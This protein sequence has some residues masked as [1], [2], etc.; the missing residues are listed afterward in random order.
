MTIAYDEK[1][2][3]GQASSA[4]L[5]ANRIEVALTA[6]AYATAAGGIVLDLESE[7]PGQTILGVVPV[8]GHGTTTQYLPFYQHGTKSIR[9]YESSADAQPL[10][11]IG[12]GDKTMTFELLVFSR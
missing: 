11:E 1:A 9:I 8:L 12:D 7:V 5:F 3:G 6:Q 10:D 4:P 2:V